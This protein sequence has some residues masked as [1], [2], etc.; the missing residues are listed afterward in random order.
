M[1]Q[2]YKSWLLF[3]MKNCRCN[4]KFW[5]FLVCNVTRVF[6][7]LQNYKFENFFVQNVTGASQSLTCAVI[8]DLFWNKKLR[9]SSNLSKIT[10]LPGILYRKDDH[11]TENFGIHIENYLFHIYNSIKTKIHTL[12]ALRTLLYETTPTKSAFSFLF[13]PKTNASKLKKPW[14]TLYY[15]FFQ[16]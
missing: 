9:I 2:N 10:S 1:F 6:K 5:L 16:P 15:P 12:L 13:S 8:I 14:K 11:I 7:W 3:Y 4:I